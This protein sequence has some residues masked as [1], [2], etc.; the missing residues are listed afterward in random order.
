MAI[1]FGDKPRRT[2]AEKG[3]EDLRARFATPIEA[4]NPANPDA[5]SDEAFSPMPAVEQS[6]KPEKRPRKRR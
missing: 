1:K 6:S 4:D 5:A 3:G 2:G